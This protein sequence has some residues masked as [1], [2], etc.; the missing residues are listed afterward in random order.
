MQ[1]YNIQ[2][3]YSFMFG[4]PPKQKMSKK[5]QHKAVYKEVYELFDFI[6]EL[7][8][9]N[10][11]NLFILFNYIPHPNT[12]M[13]NYAIKAGF[14]EPKSLKEWGNFNFGNAVTTW[15][16]NKLVKLTSRLHFMFFP[17]MSSNINNLYKNSNLIL[18]TIYNI[19]KK[20]V[21]WRW[22][23]R[24]FSFPIEYY[25]I[26][27]YHKIKQFPIYFQAKKLKIKFFTT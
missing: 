26:M 10:P 12:P 2:V 4:L 14:K 6:D 24:F 9:I 7:R 17:V 25:A 5:E 1:K 27:S 20:D 3:I 21:E 18:R 11:D 8:K 19:L 13:M 23:H 15:V 22:K 16:P